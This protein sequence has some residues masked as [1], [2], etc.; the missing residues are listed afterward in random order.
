V[1]AIAERLDDAEYIRRAL[2]GLWFYRTLN[3]ECEIAVALARRLANLPPSQASPTD[4]LV[5]ERMLG[6]SLHYLGDLANARGHLE[7]ML[8]LYTAPTPQPHIN[9]I[10]FHYDQRVAGRGT[11]ARILWLQGFPDQ[12]I[13]MAQENVENARAIDHL[14][15]LCIALDFACMIVLEVGDLATAARYVA[16]P[17]QRSA[18]HA[19]GFWRKWAHSLEGQLSIKRGDIVAGVQGLR[20][21]LYELPEM[22][23]VRKRPAL[24]GALAEGSARIGQVAEG[25]VAIDE[26]L[27]RC[28]QTAERWNLAELLRIKAELLLLESTQEATAAA[29]ELFLQ[30]LDVAHRQGALSWELRCATGLARLRRD[31]ARRQE[32]RELLTTV[33]DRFTEGFATADL[34]SAKTLIDDLSS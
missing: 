33:Y 31:Q 32:A 34:R 29:E 14:P 11:L 12:A 25:L 16:M 3:S 24:L 9:V 26:A 4:R 30:G 17:L 10:R 21:A 18:K 13:R 20:A 7:K 28:E 27:A 19:L 23:F 1:L 15:S 22:G 8:S 6:T 5:G 2:W